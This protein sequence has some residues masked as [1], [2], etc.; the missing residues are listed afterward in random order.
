M[1]ELS[2]VDHLLQAAFAAAEAHGDLSIRRVTVEIGALRQVVPE[3]LVFAFD[4]AVRDTPAE[5]AQLEWV[6]I[7]AEIACTA[8]GAH[9]RPEDVFWVCESCGAPGGRVVAGD[10]LVLRSIELA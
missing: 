6:E 10:D 9:Y 5:G 8:C 4:A 2:I 3:A 1:H 7:P